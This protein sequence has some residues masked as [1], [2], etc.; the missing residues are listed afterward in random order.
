MI[1]SHQLLIDN[2]I[3]LP[4]LC[5]ILESIAKS[6]LIF[7][8]IKVYLRIF[9][10]DSLCNTEQK[11][12]QTTHLLLCLYCCRCPDVSDVYVTIHHHDESWYPNSQ[13]RKSMWSMSVCAGNNI[14][15]IHTYTFYIF[16]LKSSKK[17]AAMSQLQ[18]ER[19]KESTSFQSNGFSVNPAHW[20]MWTM[21]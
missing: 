14:S 16:S 1:R 19:V 2:N 20:N 11:Q 6:F 3:H 8:G 18:R 13:T 10:L 4:F 15:S 12:H 5:N 7:Y 9:R 21:K 17:G